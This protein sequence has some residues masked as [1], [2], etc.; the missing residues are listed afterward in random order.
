MS[1]FSAMNISASALSSERLRMDVISGNIANANTT[2]GANGEAY[3]RKIAVFEENLVNANN[4]L[5]SSLSGVK[6]SGIIE[7][8]SELKQV[9]DPTHPD[10]NEEGYYSM[11]NVDVTSEII[12]L[13]VAQRA[14]QLN[15]TAVNAAKSMYTKALEIG[16]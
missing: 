2:R 13:M 5:S 6:A 3:R 14:Y 1:V 15:V 9:Y 8:N 4:G 7:D 12:D 10:A 16:R 11:P